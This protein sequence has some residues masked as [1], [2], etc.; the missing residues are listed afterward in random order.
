MFKKREHYERTLILTTIALMTILVFTN[1]GDT[2]VL[3]LYL[4]VSFQWTL[5]KFSLYTSIIS[6]A[7]IMG[8]ITGVYLLHK[9]LHIREIIIILIGCV[10][11]LFSSLF[12]GLANLSWQIY[13]GKYS[14][15]IIEALKLVI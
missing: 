5:Q 10:S 13:A 3:Y 15:C 14:F 2:A 4:R 1:F 12:Q 8:G 6:G 11:A 9:I 7:G